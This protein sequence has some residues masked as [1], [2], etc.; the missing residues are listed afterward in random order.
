MRRKS[1]VEE[2]VVMMDITSVK[3]DGKKI[4]KIN[5]TVSSSKSSSYGE[6][7]L[8]FSPDGSQK[9][10]PIYTTVETRRTTSLLLATE[11]ENGKCIIN[12]RITI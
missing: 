10:S 4:Y 12:D 6:T 7:P 1:S 5:P 11:S 9:W 8:Y 2:M 3:N